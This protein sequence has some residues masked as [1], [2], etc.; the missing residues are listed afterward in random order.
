MQWGRDR[1]GPG[2]G[3]KKD[4]DQLGWEEDLGRGGSY[5]GPDGGERILRGGAG[6]SDVRQ[7][8]GASHRQH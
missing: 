6:I 5:A 3:E 1:T 2:E 4:L 8:G 7:L